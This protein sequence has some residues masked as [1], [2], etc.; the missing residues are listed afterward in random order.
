MPTS[1]AIGAISASRASSF[2]RLLVDFRRQPGLN[3]LLA[4]FVDLLL[5]NVFLAQFVLDDAHLLAQINLALR[6]IHL[7]MHLAGDLVLQ[8]E[9]AQF[10]TEQFS[11]VIE[12]LFDVEHFQQALAFFRSAAS[13][14]R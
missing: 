12:P 1:G 14:S 4:D 3:D 10:L 13:A 2:M 5:E 8:F 11:D 9:H 6:A 7:L